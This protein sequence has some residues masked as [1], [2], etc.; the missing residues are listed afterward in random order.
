MYKLIDLAS[1]TPFDKFYPC[2]TIT[3][4]NYTQDTIFFAKK[5]CV[6]AGR[7]VNV[8]DYI[9]SESLKEHPEMIFPLNRK[10]AYQ[11]RCALRHSPGI[12]PILDE[13]FE[14]IGVE[15]VERKY[16]I[17]SALCC[18]A[19]FSRIGPDRIKPLMAGNLQDAT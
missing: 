7:T 13:L 18:G 8:L 17:E 16:D 6:L 9:L 5:E 4:H 10:I 19:L 1:Q 2:S 12:E 14:P 11:R 3:F 15:R